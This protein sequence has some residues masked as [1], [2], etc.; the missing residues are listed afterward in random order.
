MNPS[1]ICR[2][3]DALD[4]ARRAGADAVVE[5]LLRARERVAGPRAGVTL[6]TD[7]AALWTA[8][9]LARAR[10]ERLAGRHGDAGPADD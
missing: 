3:D 1:L 8:W 9:R 4:H 2:I 7:A 10:Y 5:R 6:S